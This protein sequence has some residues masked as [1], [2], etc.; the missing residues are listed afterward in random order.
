MEWEIVDEAAARIASPRGEI[1]HKTAD[2]FEENLL[3]AL[4]EAPG[5]TL[6]LDMSQVTYMSSVG[7][8]VIMLAVKQTKSSGTK[9][10]VCGLNPTLAEI[11]HITRFGKIVTIHENLEAARAAG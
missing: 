2:A 3:P 8:R 9:F 1:D 6:I 10:S 4:S 5:N 11:F 7:L